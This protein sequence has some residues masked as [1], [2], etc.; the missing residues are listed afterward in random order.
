MKIAYFS[1]RSQGPPKIINK[2]GAVIPLEFIK[3]RE[4]LFKK[5]YDL[6]VLEIRVNGLWNILELLSRSNVFI[7]VL[8]NDFDLQDIERCY[9]LG[10]HDIFS[11]PLKPEYLRYFWGK[12][13]SKE[14]IFSK[15]NFLTRDNEFWRELKKINQLFIDPGPVLLKGPTG[16]GKTHLATMIHDYL[17]GKNKPF[18]SFNCSEFAESLIESELFGHKKGSF[19]GA[20]SDKKGLLSQ[21]HN[22]SLFLDE[23]GTMPITTQ[24]KLLKALEEKCFYPVGAGESEKSSFQLISATC[25]DILE[26]GNFRKDFY[27]RLEGFVLDIKPLKDRPYDI[28]LLINKFLKDAPRKIIISDAAMDLLKEYHWPGNVRELKNL[29]RLIGPV[30]GG[31]VKTCDLPEKICNFLG[32]KHNQI[33]FLSNESVTNLVSEVGLS[34]V[35]E[36]FENEAFKFFYLKNEGKVRKTMKQL[37]ISNNTFY[38]IK[39]RVF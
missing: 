25:E 28:P 39:K 23:I 37:K 15:F 9:R 20:I 3:D 24:K 38:R 2:A 27:Y 19:T 8:G 30:D 11:P 18:V 14:F 12:Y 32:K 22:G 7:M 16:V 5:K 33:S 31:V 21:A 36:N 34:M 17:I 29:I 1:D 10:C 6:V 26:D 35:M 13:F 4:D